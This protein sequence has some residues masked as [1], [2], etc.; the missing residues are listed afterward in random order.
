MILRATAASHSFCE[1]A[2]IVS[3]TL[4]PW[5]T[6]SSEARQMSAY[7][8]TSYKV[9]WRE[10]LKLHCHLDSLPDFHEQLSRRRRSPN[11]LILCR[12]NSFRID[13]PHFG[14]F[15]YCT[16]S[17]Y[18]IDIRVY[19]HTSSNKLYICF[20]SSHHVAVDIFS[21]SAYGSCSSVS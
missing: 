1:F 4:L 17:M 5:C 7:K 8:T 11:S 16:T 9:L 21:G 2:H 10:T 18:N 14:S 15:I 6:N 19:K 20:T 3:S 13:F 12:K